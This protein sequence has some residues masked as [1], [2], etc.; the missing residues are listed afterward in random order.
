[1]PSPPPTPEAERA[2]LYRR[3]QKAGIQVLPVKVDHEIVDALI[4]DGRL[5]ADDALD[6]GKLADALLEK[7]G[8]ENPEKYRHA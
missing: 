4:A 6:T 7:A 1:M 2:R 8:F 5:S 3:R